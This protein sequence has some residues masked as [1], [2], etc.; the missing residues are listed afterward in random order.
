MRA[1]TVRVVDDAEARMTTA[2]PG[3]YVF[4]SKWERTMGGLLAMT[5]V[6]AA[7][8]QIRAPAHAALLKRL[9]EIDGFAP[10]DDRDYDPVR[11]A[12]ELLGARP[13]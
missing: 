7:L 12:I 6:R 2:S 10:A 5:K 3:R 9:Y 13:R 1:L 8:L 11:A 4:L